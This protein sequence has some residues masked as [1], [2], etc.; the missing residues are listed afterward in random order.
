MKFIKPADL[1]LFLFIDIVALFD[2]YLIRDN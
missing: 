1:V 2:L